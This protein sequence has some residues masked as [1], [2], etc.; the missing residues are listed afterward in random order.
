MTP[1]ALA[2]VLAALLVPGP[3][4]AAPQRVCRIGDARLDEL[5]GLAATADGGYIVVNDGSDFASHRRIFFL[6]RR[7]A[8]TRA[9]AYP[10]R[11]R[12][13]EDLA[14]AADGTVWVGDIGDNGLN[15]D[16]IALWRLAP[17]ART[18]RLY[19]LAYPDGPH[20]AEAL[21]LTSAG[22]PVIV[23]KTVAAAGVYVPEGPLDAGR[24]TPLRRAGGVTLPMTTTSNPFSLPGRLVVT[25]GAAG[26]DGRRATLRTYAD[27][28]EFDVPGGD[29]VRALTR[30]TPR[31]IPLPDEPQ[32]ESVAYTPDGA[33]LLT[34]SEVARQ[35]AGTRPE[36]LRYPLPDRPATAVASPAA[37]SPARSSSASPA[38][39]SAPRRD[40]VPVGGLVTGALLAGA[41]ALLGI[42]AARRRR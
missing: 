41:A 4:A 20:D 19:R 42:R 9:V 35:P 16:T 38:A 7:C 23:T 2:A 5:S 31:V 34:V 24:T 3:V 28:F 36:L 1:P 13:T 11:P 27:A 18:P 40:R 21:L 32:G 14:L 10:S 33:A 8:V 6:D 26:P 22:T 29:L 15:R 25:G 12:D 39:A 30:G 37:A 17:G